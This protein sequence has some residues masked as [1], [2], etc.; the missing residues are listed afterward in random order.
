MET[1]KT[2]SA[3]TTLSLQAALKIKIMNENKTKI[4][5][6]VK[7]VKNYLKWLNIK[8][9]SCRNYLFRSSISMSR[10]KTLAYRRINVKPTKKEWKNQL[11]TI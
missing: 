11:T 6:T 10:L 1:V 2:N 3:I 9:I 7:N 5:R 4:N 8:N